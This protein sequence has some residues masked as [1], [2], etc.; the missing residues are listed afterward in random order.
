MMTC[1]AAKRQS[2]A[3]KNQAIIVA[4]DQCA[5]AA[6]GNRDFFLNKPPARG[7]LTCRDCVCGLFSPQLIIEFVQVRLLHSSTI[8]RSGL[9]AF[10]TL[11]MCFTHPERSARSHESDDTGCPQDRGR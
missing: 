7:A 2:L 8:V 11:A 10:N 6:T 5:E 1:K 3:A 4:I 9:V